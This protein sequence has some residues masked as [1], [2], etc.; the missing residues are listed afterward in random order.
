MRLAYIGCRNVHRPPL[1]QPH[2]RRAI[3]LAGRMHV[4]FDEQRELPAA[5]D[6]LAAGAGDGTLGAAAAEPV[7]GTLCAVEGGDAAGATACPRP[8]R[9][10][11][12]A[13]AIGRE[14][15]PATEAGGVA[16]GVR[17]AAPA[18]SRERAV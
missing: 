2:P 8:D 5:H 11:G 14:S 12:A 17:L 10:G 16:A 7:R 18:V 13:R 4:P 1:P 6:G 15:R 9:G 3:P